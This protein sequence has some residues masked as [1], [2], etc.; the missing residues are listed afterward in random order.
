MNYYTN[1]IRNVKGDT[2]SCAMSIDGL[3]Q[4]LESVYFTCRD[5]L[6]DDSEVLF[7][8]ELDDGISLVEYD[9]EKDIRKYAIRVAPAQ[10]KNIQTGTY[11]YDLQVGINSDIFTIMRGKFIVEQE[12]SREGGTN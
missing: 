6:N 9:Q 8:A 12:C 2:F 10:T 4:D 11:Y 3:G 1:D 5:G 7:E